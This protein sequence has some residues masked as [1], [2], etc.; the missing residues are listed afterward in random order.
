[1]AE[2][3]N[4]TFHCDAPDCKSYCEISAAVIDGDVVAALEARG[5]RVDEGRHVCPGHREEDKSPP[6]LPEPT[7][8]GS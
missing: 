8:A 4:R 3:R 2:V 1:M 6:R 5:W 7:A